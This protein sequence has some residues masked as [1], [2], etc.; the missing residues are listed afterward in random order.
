MA[1]TSQFTVYSSV[2]ASHPV[3]NGLSGSL[4]AV[5]N[6]CLV[7]G[8]GSKPGA[9]WTK[10]GSIGP[11]NGIA[12]SDATGSGIFVMPTGSGATFYVMD[13]GLD[14]PAGRTA[15]LVGYDYI[16]QTGPQ[17]GSSPNNITGSN[18]FPTNTQISIGGGSGYVSIRKSTSNDATE[19][20]WTIFADS[21][22]VYMFFATGDIAGVYIGHFFG[23][24]YSLK[25]SGQD[26]YKAMVIA[27]HV[28]QAGYGT[29]NDDFDVLSLVNDSTTAHFLQRSYSG[30]VGSITCGKHGDGA[31]GSTT[32][33][34]GI[35]Q[36]VNGPDSGLYL[37]PI[38]VH[39]NASACIRG[40]MRGL[41]HVCHP[42]ANFSDGQ[43][44]SFTTGDY[45]GRT[46]RILKTTPNSGMI[47]ME[48]SATVE[49]N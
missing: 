7:T 6:G 25:S 40:R 14:V 48:T 39:E 23:D 46:F 15:R 21:S 32:V 33:L 47:C 28:N 45:A 34:L 27:N 19:R 2:D 3:L 10:T 11:A 38:W 36:Y 43:I 42:I 37:S 4:L 16:T 35:T 22:S 5:L 41:W 29:T 30:T 20:Q 24:I 17:T 8:Y 49:T 13:G 9:G 44:I 26:A 31:K 18:Q 12:I 1:Y